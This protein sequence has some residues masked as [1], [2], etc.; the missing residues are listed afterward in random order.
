M[1]LFAP[2][3]ISGD[4]TNI[5]DGETASAHAIVLEVLTL[6]D[7]GLAK[8]AGKSVVDLCMCTR[9]CAILSLARLASVVLRWHM[10]GCTDSQPTSASEIVG[11]FQRKVNRIMWSC[12]H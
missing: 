6:G 10:H 8:E 11:A 3:G 12:S 4:I 5:S 7:S 2:S 1:G 9:V